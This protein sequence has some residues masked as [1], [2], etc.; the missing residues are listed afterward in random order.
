MLFFYS[1][2]GN[3]APHVHV[4]AADETAKFWLIPGG[5]VKLADGR[6]RPATMKRVAALVETHA[7]ECREKWNE[8]FC[9]R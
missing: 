2:E 8:Y 1:N 9:S 3:E 6:M 5:V 4:E 7:I